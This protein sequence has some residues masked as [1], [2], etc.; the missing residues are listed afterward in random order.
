MDQSCVAG[1]G[2][3]YRAEI[4]FKA[5]LHPEQPCNTLSREDFD[6]VW[7]HSSDLLKRGVKTGSILTVDANEGLPPPWTRRYIYN[8]SHCGRCGSRVQSWS[9]ANRTVYACPGGQPLRTDSGSEDRLKTP[10]SSRAVADLIGSKRAQAIGA[11][12]PVKVRP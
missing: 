12:T 11:A 2:N 9:I 5:G 4:L 10:N 3:I 8:H 6:S 7:K 1:I